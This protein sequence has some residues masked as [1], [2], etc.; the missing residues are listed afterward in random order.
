MV[1]AGQ[2]SDPHATEYI[3]D[4]LV[5]RQRATAAYWFARVNPLDRFAVY[6]DRLCFDDLAV[7][8]RFA[9][10]ASTRYAVRRYDRQAQPLG[11]S[12]ARGVA[13]GR[14]CVPLTLPADGDGYTMV[15]IA[16]TRPGFTGA[17]VVHIARDP[18]SNAP[19]VIGI[20]RE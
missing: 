3:T 2:L 17:T 4:T 11:T 1:E 5:A 18:A 16:T 6:R 19:R 9:D 12:D 20:W 8:Y 10:V 7:A 15:Q 14:V 13:D